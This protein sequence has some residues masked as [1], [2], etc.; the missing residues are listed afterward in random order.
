[1]LLIVTFVHVAGSVAGWLCGRR[2][3]RTLKVVFYR[4]RRVACVLVLTC[5]IVSS[6]R[7]SLA[8]AV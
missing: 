6:S 5:S 3:Q 4:G 2:R 8:E 1:M 7:M